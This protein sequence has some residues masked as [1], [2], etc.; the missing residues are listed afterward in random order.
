MADESADART[1][2]VALRSGD[3]DELAA[4]GLVNRGE[5]MVAVCQ[6]LHDFVFGVSAEERTGIVARH[7][8]AGLREVVRAEAEERRGLII[9]RQF[10]AL[11]SLK[12]RFMDTAGTLVRPRLPFL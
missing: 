11:V 4:A 5:R 9:F 12:V 7:A 3:L 8:E 6:D 1:G 2:L 10:T